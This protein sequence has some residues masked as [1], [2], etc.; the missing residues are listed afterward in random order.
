M[1]LVPG[2]DI[3]FA[4]PW[5]CADAFVVFDA[6]SGDYWAVARLAH[7]ILQ[8]VRSDDAGIALPALTEQLTTAHAAEDLIHTLMPTLQSLVDNQLLQPAG[9][10]TA[11]SLAT[12]D[13]DD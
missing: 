2:R 5:D 1:A 8:L 6:N 12:S 13:P 7:D 4:P 11:A 3:R 9:W 10:Y